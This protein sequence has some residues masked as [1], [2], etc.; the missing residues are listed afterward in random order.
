MAE[1]ICIREQNYSG[2]KSQFKIKNIDKIFGKTDSENIM[3]LQTYLQI[4]PIYLNEKE[5]PEPDEDNA[6]V[7]V[8]QQIDERDAPFHVAYVL[9][10]DGLTTLTIETDASRPNVK[11]SSFDIYTTNDRIK[12]FHS[13]HMNIHLSS[14][15]IRPITVI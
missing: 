11:T 3:Y 8:I 14:N 13:R 15:G 12:S 4:H 6:N 5:N 10:K 7:I 2:N 9:L 1:G